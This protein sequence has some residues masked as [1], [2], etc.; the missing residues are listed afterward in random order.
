[1]SVSYGN[2][3]IVW[4]KN[5]AAKLN[6][7]KK[8]YKYCKKKIINTYALKQ[9]RIVLLSQKSWNVIKIK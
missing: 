5:Y 1:M 8:T 4:V 6:L 3:V 2:I 9:F 7:N